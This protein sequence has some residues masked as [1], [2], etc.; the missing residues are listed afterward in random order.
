MPRSTEGKRRL[1]RLL[2]RAVRGATGTATLPLVRPEAAR[3]AARE[4]PAA[5]V[6]T[7][8]TGRRAR[9]VRR[10]AVTAGALCAA[11]TAVLL[12]SFLGATPFAPRSVLPVPGVPS[13]APGTVRRT[14]WPTPTVPATSRPAPTVSPSPTPHPSVT[15]VPSGSRTVPVT[16]G[17]PSTSP[18]ESTT[19]SVTATATA[20]VTATATATASLSAT[21]RTPT[22]TGSP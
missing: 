11:Y 6:F 22:A 4:N 1:R 15:P 18:P 5:P 13:E 14:P 10:L 17:P 12:L 19:P 9:V 8:R 2:A 7:D 16:T 3:S 21:P 20:T